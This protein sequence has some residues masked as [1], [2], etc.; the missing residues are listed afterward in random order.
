M[1]VTA[2]GGSDTATAAAKTTAMVWALFVVLA[3]FYDVAVLLRS[4]SGFAVA[5]AGGDAADGRDHHRRAGRHQQTIRIGVI[6]PYD[7]PY[8]WALPKTRPGIEYAIAEVRRRRLLPTVDVRVEYGDSR[9]SDIYGPLVAID[10]YHKRTAD[11][12]IGPACDYSVA[13][14]ARFSPHWNIPVITGGALVQAFVDKRQ[15][16]LLTR[17]SGSYAELGAFA[18]RLFAGVFGWT[19]VGLV[20]SSNLGERQRLGKTD[21]YFVMEAVYLL[22]KRRYKRA[23][24][25]GKDLWNKPI[26]DGDWRTRRRD[27]PPQ[28]LQPHLVELLTEA[29][30]NARSTN[31]RM[32]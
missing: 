26:D 14:I 6:L 28:P 16:R 27:E 13:P 20:Y 22:L 15:Y 2:R 23:F 17:I 25:D 30:L 3:D 5:A 7:G 11:V 1:I 12:F 19:T 8:A 10:M 31:P 9:C 18:D 21:C 24:G 32:I 29:S 4:P